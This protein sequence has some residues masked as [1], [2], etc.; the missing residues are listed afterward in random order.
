MN[1]YRE[2]TESVLCAVTVTMCWF[3]MKQNGKGAYQGIKVN[4]YFS[5]LTKCPIGFISTF[6]SLVLGYLKS[7]EICPDF[8][9][10]SP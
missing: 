9:F 1:N 10:H 3:T 5:I 2:L 6:I 7:F 4:K 8:N